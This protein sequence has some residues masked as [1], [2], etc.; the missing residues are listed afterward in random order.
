VRDGRQ[1]ASETETVEVSVPTPVLQ[2][3][4]RT[5]EFQ[6]RLDAGVTSPGFSQRLNAR[7]YLLGWLRG[8]A[9]YG[10]APV[11][12]VIANRHIEPSANS[13]LFRTQ[14]AVFGAADPKLENAVRRGWFCMAVQDAEALYG[15]YTGNNPDIANDIC[16]A[17]EYIFGEKHSG[18]LPDADSL[19]GQIGE[20]TGT[21]QKQTIGVNE[22]AYSPLR[23]LVAGSDEHSIEEAIERAL[24]IETAIHNDTQV[25]D[26]LEFYHEQ[27]HPAASGTNT[28]RRQEAIEV[29]TDTGTIE[30]GNP[31][32]NGTYYRF[33][34]IRISI[35][36]RE[37]KTWEWN[38]SGLPQSVITNDTDTL[39]ATVTVVLAENETAPNLYIEEFNG[40]L[41][42]EHKYKPGPNATEDVRTVPVGFRNYADSADRVAE[43]V[44]GGTNHS[45]FEDWLGDRW[46]NVT[47]ADNLTLPDTREAVLDLAPEQEE[48]L[49]STA[50]DDTSLLQQTVES[51]NH[52]F[53]RSELVRGHEETGPVGKLIEKVENE[54]TTYLDRTVPY[55]SVGQQVIYEVRYAYFETLIDDLERVESAH[56]EVMSGLDNHLEDIDSSLDDAISFLQAGLS[57]G[58]TDGGGDQT[59]DSPSITPEITYSVSGSP[60][61]LAG[62]PVTS[63]DVPAVDEEFSSFAAKNHNYLKLPYDTIVSGIL[64]EV[65][66]FLGV[67]GEDVQLTLRAAGEALR[68]GEL[69]ERAADAG[70]GEYADSDELNKLNGKLT[71]ALD[72][73]LEEFAVE[74]GVEVV[75]EL[76]GADPNTLF[77]YYDN[78]T[79]SKAMQTTALATN[80]TL[81]GY[82]V[83][84]AAIAVGGGNATEPLVENISDALDDEEIDR[85]KYARNLSSDGW[86]EVVASAVRPAVDR[87]AANATATLE[88][89]DV[90]ESLDTATRQALENVSSDIVEERLGSYLNGTFDL[91]KFENWVGAGNSTDTPIRVPA[92]LP[93]LPLPSMW[94]ATM[95][96]W[97]IEAD[98]RY[99]RFEVEANM[100][101]PGRATSTTYVRENR[102][103][104]LEIGGETRTLGTVEPIEFDGR[105][106]LVVVV[107]PGGIGVGDRDD[108]NPECTETYPVVG[109]FDEERTTCE[110]LGVGSNAASNST[111][112]S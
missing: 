99:A 4:D 50:L 19:T 32:Q 11:T 101:A 71:E 87:A 105:S 46:G 75:R 95:N 9:Q 3:H 97:N 100:S 34:D 74:M 67:G 61:Y 30:R 62:E 20:A 109:P 55:E 73:G 53:E 63:D 37:G 18:D 72:D 35:E 47:S 107:P 91:S 54:R 90:V 45:A 17:S 31:A 44:V 28:Q 102:T 33:S 59:F 85:P 69:A 103:V 25:N 83:S 58:G 92:G 66:N 88:S 56:S 7:T 68:A 81:E 52:T 43:G 8:Y 12:E 65:L 48:L 41:G 14:Q 1:V 111:G 42:V 13:A 16:T 27:P 5:E 80:E 26:E 84:E 21:N 104:D 86:R 49:V 112:D 24:T 40:E 51:I 110:F 77:P 98:G 78:D 29:N 108:E 70:G 36:V 38:S 10:G 89:P 106:L 22:T 39:E 2:Q 93:L 6:S 94:V 79:H 96:I 57:P 64:N 60:T 23:T 82:R 76:Y 15:G